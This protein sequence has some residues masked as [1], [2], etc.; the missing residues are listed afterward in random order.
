MIGS[1]LYGPAGAFL[2]VPVAAAIQVVLNET[3]QPA[4]EEEA[5]KIPGPQ[6]DSRA[7]FIPVPPWSERTAEAQDLC[8]YS[9]A[10]KKWTATASA[11]QGDAGQDPDLGERPGWSRLRSTG[12]APG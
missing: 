1:I 7:R 2:A 9:W 10:A 11:E 4:L 12:S 6:A 5:L 3:L 8:V